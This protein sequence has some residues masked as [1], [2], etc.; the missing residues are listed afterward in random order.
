MGN[1]IEILARRWRSLPYGKD[2]EEI[3]N[4][5]QLLF[6]PFSSIG[7]MAR[8]FLPFAR[9][10]H[11]FDLSKSG[12]SIRSTCDYLLSAPSCTAS[13][14]GSSVLTYLLLHILLPN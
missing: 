7:L 14:E 8:L 10:T 5:L 4:I 2:Q 1:D 6:V 13:L 3:L 11:S 9:S 12:I